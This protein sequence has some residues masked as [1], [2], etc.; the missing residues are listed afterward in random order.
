MG[1]GLE[2]CRTWPSGPP[3]RAGVQPGGGGRRCPSSGLLSAEP[4]STM[5]P[6]AQRLD[7]DVPGK[8]VK[9][10]G[11]TG[12]APTAG[13][14][15]WVTMLQLGLQDWPLY[16]EEDDFIH[17]SWGAKGTHKRW[18]PYHS[19]RV[20]V[21]LSWPRALLIL[22]PPPGCGSVPRPWLTSSQAAAPWPWG[23]AP[24]NSA[25]TGCR[26][27]RGPIEDA[28]KKERGLRHTV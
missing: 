14:Q 12:Q 2:E 17:R 22:I 4:G 25:T 13:G 19:D 1:G 9:G 27:G 23:Q 16:R 6:R 15:R 5:G 24:G 21:L 20:H 8:T 10:S 11:I 7:W 26:A 3:H 28:V 18:W